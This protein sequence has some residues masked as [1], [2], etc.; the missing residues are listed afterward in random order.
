MPRLVIIS[1]ALLITAASCGKDSEYFG[2]AERKKVNAAQ[3][4][5]E[6][7][8]NELSK[9]RLDGVRALAEKKGP[10]MGSAEA[11]PIDLQGQ[12]DDLGKATPERLFEVTTIDK[13]EKKVERHRRTRMRSRINMHNGEM[14][15]AKKTEMDS[16]LARAKEQSMPAYWGTYST[17]I[18]DS[19]TKAE[20]VGDLSEGKGGS[21]KPGTIVGRMFV[22]DFA[23]SAVVCVAPVIAQSSSLVKVRYSKIDTNVGKRTSVSGLERDLE[24]QAFRAAVAKA[25]AV[26]DASVPYPVNISDLGPGDATDANDKAAGGQK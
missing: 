21:M 18:V 25:V 6:K 15:L 7:L 13:L 10:V 1:L 11:C 17:I 2:E 9:K 19:R 14:S 12:L 4:A 3:E 26:G 5:P 16:F 20:V 24:R 8:V 23:K 22:W